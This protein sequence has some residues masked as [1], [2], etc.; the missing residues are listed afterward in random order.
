ML[1]TI[2]NIHYTTVYS[3]LTIHLECMKDVNIR[4][5]I[6]NNINHL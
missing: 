2:C 5:N 6:K 3:C 4:D 1:H